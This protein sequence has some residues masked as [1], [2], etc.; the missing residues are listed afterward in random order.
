VEIKIL[1][2][3]IRIVPIRPKGAPTAYL[4]LHFRVAVNGPLYLAASSGSQAANAEQLRNCTR[5]N[6]CPRA[7]VVTAKKKSSRDF[8]LRK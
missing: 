5:S 6:N 4:K 3:F 2:V 1:I 7:Q 8:A